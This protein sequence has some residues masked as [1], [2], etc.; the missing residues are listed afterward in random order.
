MFEKCPQGSLKS[1]NNS[2]FK[3]EPICSKEYPFETV[4]NKQCV[5]YCPIKYYIQNLCIT[6]YELQK[7]ANKSEKEE[8][9]ITVQDMILKNIEILK[10]IL[11][12]KNIIHQ[13]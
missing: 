3:C 8:T 9:E 13:I 1:E 2:D 7:Y 4:L 10:L 6:N 12:L 11:L 5:K